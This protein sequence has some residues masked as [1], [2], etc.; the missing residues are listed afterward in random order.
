[1]VG[2]F[3]IWACTKK[4]VVGRAPLLETLDHGGRHSR[5]PPEFVRPSR[6][7]PLPSKI[8]QT[9]AG[10]RASLL[11]HPILRPLW[12]IDGSPSLSPSTHDE[13]GGDRRGSSRPG[14]RAARRLIAP[15]FFLAPAT[16]A[17][18][19]EWR[20]RTTEG[21]AGG[22]SRFGPGT[23]TAGSLSPTSLL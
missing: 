1:M 8:R 18:A 10:R 9:H 17:A 15:L 4:E 7:E 19:S 13:G 2:I 14:R 6:I 21:D 12:K 22:S 3:Y 11:P 23:D 16:R 20:S 5:L